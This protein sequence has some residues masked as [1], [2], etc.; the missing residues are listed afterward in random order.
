VEKTRIRKVEI[1]TKGPRELKVRDVYRA[2][3]YMLMEIKIH[4]KLYRQVG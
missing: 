2:S 1:K 3:V 4:C